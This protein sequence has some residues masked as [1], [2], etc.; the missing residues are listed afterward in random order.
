VEGWSLDRNR[1]RTP[2]WVCLLGEGPFNPT[3]IWGPVSNTA[4]LLK[5]SRE[6]HEELENLSSPNPAEVGQ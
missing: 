6:L 3:W 4:E 1:T 2:L 5:T